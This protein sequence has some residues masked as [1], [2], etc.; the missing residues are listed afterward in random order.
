MNCVELFNNLTHNEINGTNKKVLNKLLNRFDQYL[1]LKNIIKNDMEISTDVIR[2]RIVYTIKVSNKE[3]EKELLKLNGDIIKR[4]KKKYLI[5]TRKLS[6]KIIEL[7]FQK[8]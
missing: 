4:K 5:N 6:S 3:V 2:N 1:L 7:Y 8:Q